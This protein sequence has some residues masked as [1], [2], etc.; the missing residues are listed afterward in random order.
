MQQTPPSYV[1]GV[2][3]LRLG[4]LAAVLGEPEAGVRLLAAC[5]VVDK[6]IGHPD[7][8]AE[9]LP[10]A[11]SAAEE[12]GYDESRLQVMLAEIEAAYREDRGW[13]LVV[14]AFPEAITQEPAE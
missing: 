8:E 14:A 3:F 9:V 1:E 4:Q 7:A 11:R 10:I 5:Y 12:L 2:I 6:Q 13:G